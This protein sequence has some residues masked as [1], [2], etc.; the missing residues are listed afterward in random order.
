M[1]RHVGT[2]LPICDLRHGRNREKSE[3]CKIQGAGKVLSSLLSTFDLWYLE[4]GIDKPWASNISGVGE[5]FYFFRS[6]DDQ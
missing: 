5:F 6:K 2:S 1:S 3:E 4:G